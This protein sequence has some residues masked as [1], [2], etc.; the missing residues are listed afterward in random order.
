MPERPTLV[1]LAGT[2]GSGKSSI[3]GEALRAK[4]GDYFNPDEVTRILLDENPSLDLAAANSLAW[5]LNVRKLRDAIA[6]GTPYAFETTLGGNTI[7]ALLEE[8]ADKGHKLHLWYVGLGSPELHLQRIAERVARGGLDIPPEKVWQRYLTSLRNLV[9]LMPKAFEIQVYD[10]STDGNPALVP[11]T[12]RLVL[13]VLNGA[14]E[15]PAKLGQLEATPAWVKPVV[16]CA[17]DHFRSPF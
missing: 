8:A 14:I 13:H 16:V 3:G 5:Q 17:F 11:P 4:G 15:Y 7:P 10:N 12:P 9:K 1:V 2:N 6:S